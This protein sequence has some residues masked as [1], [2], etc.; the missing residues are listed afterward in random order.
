ML[1]GTISDF[2]AEGLFGV[3]DSDDGRLLLFNL[4]Q[5]DAASRAQFKIGTRVEF[6]EQR[7]EPAPRAL[8]ISPIV[9]A[10]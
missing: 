1:T 8:A 9:T 2:D 4:K 5:T 6:A 10:G 7:G 3:I